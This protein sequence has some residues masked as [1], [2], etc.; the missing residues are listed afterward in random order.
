MVN[1]VNALVKEVEVTLK[2]VV[3]SNVFVENE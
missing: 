1:A 2:G 3:S